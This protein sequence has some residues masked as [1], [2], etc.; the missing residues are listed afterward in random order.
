[1]TT[2]FRIENA[3]RKKH[4]PNKTTLKRLL[5]QWPVAVFATIRISRFIHI[6]KNVTLHFFKMTWNYSRFSHYLY[7]AL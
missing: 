6:F 5:H 2:V 7:C 1:L 3:E 4:D